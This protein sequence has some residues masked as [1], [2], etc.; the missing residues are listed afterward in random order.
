MRLVRL[1]ASSLA[2]PAASRLRR[3]KQKSHSGA[4]TFEGY[5]LERDAPDVC[6]GLALCSTLVTTANKRSRELINQGHGLGSSTIHNQSKELAPADGVTLPTSSPNSSFQTHSQS[7]LGDQSEF[8]FRRIVAEHASRNRPMDLDPDSDD[9]DIDKDDDDEDQMDIL[10]QQGYKASLLPRRLQLGEE[11]SSRLLPAEPAERLA[12]P[13]LDERRQGNFGMHQAL[14]FHPGTYDIILI[15]DAREVKNQRDND[16]I[17]DGLKEKGVKVDVRALSIGDMC[18][19]ARSKDEKHVGEDKE[20]V[21]DYVV[22]RKRLDDLCSSIRDGRYD[23]QKVGCLP[24]F[25][26]P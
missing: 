13:D 23:E 4:F 25:P 22:E 26:L 10:G 19:I 9:N 18:W 5:L 21:L 3:L 7:I 1:E 24:W 17:R 12:D 20:C 14:T 16:L 8:P 6:P 15:M 11:G 2:H